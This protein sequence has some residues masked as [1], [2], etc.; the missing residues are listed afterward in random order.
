MSLCRSVKISIITHR[1]LYVFVIKSPEVLNDQMITS[2][3]LLNIGVF[4]KV[5]IFI[6]IDIEIFSFFTANGNL[7]MPQGKDKL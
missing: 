1:N 7:N 5:Y 4:P 6:D 3:I 2:L